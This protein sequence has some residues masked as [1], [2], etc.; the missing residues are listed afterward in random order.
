MKAAS[1]L[2]I[3]A[4]T[5]RSHTLSV[6]RSFGRAGAGYDAAAVLQA[7][8]R[9]RL[10]RRLDPITITPQVILDAG[11][12]TG[13]ASEALQV[14]Y[15][16][17]QVIALDSAFGM[18]CEATRRGS[19]VSPFHK[20]CADAEHLPLAA[21]SVDLIISNLMLQWCRP[22][23][24]FAEFRRVLAPQGRLNFT[25]LGPGTLHEL[26]SAWAAVDSH[27]HVNRFIATHDL[28]AAMSRAGFPA[29]ALDVEHYTMTYANVHALAM[30]LK[31]IGAQSVIAGRS[32]GLTG[33]RRFAA[34]ET[35]YE[36]F[37]YNDRL[38]ASYEILFGQ[39]SPATQS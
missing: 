33:P 21:G 29:P 39:A 8:A 20:V 13:H 27:S 28:L 31:A 11:A 12:G 7:V 1:N 9:E 25:T 38:P 14:R 10:L 23:A 37:R 30:D 15:P 18:L 6:R 35:A 16:E 2:P 5:I 4:E 36:T 22:D 17:S 26:R 3:K 34:M 19:L 32:K 24:V